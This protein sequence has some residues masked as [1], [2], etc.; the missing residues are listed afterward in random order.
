MKE[1]D[2][3]TLFG[4]YIKAK[5]PKKS[6]IFE[7]K[8]CKGTS[9]PFNSVA[10]HQIQALIDATGDTD[11]GFYH[12]I[13]DTPWG[14]IDKFRYTSLKPFDCFYLTGIEAFIVIWFYHERKP[15]KFIFIPI[16]IFLDERDNSERKSLTEIRAREI[17]TEI[18][19]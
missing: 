12:K 1:R 5:K 18:T 13:T 19:L 9:L 17:G 11:M 3:Q 4:K 10:E 15:K 2:F 6:T 14:T 7:L 16:S 8:I